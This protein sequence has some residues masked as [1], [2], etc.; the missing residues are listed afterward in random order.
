MSTLF[1]SMILLQRILYLPPQLS[2]LQYSRWRYAFL[3]SVYMSG[4]S[5]QA[6]HFLSV[7]NS[8]AI[9]YL[10]KTNGPHLYHNRPV[11]FILNALD[12]APLLKP[13]MSHWVA[14]GY[15]EALEARTQ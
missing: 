15:T 5:V 13:S 2:T 9:T 3:L 10:R 1:V 7:R 6:T 4:L 12:R 8:V 14:R 11:I